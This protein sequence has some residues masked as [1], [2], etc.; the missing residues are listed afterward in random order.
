MEIRTVYKAY[1]TSLYHS[2]PH[3]CSTTLNLTCPP[4]PTHLP[5]TT[6]THHY[7]LWIYCSVVQMCIHSDQTLYRFCGNTTRQ[8]K[9]N[10]TKH[11][12]RD[13]GRHTNSIPSFLHPTIH[14]V[15]PHHSKQYGT[16]VAGS[17]DTCTT[18]CS[19]CECLQSSHNGTDDH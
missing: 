18:P 10:S 17:N 19:A 11:T 5:L 14:T 2:W 12:H 1:H 3:P 7:M 8:T 15:Y 9:T 16:Q 6:S 4:P 13:R